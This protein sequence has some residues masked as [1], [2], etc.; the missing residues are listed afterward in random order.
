MRFRVE[1]WLRLDPTPEPVAFDTVLQLTTREYTVQ[2][3]D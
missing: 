1:G 3:R 2:G